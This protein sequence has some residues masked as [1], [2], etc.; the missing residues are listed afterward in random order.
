MFVDK[1]KVMVQAGDGGSGVI[2]FRQE[3]FVDHGGP[4]GGD[5]GKGG[6]V[7]FV[8]SNNQNTLAA[9]RHQKELKAEPGGNGSKQKKH[10]KNG[11]DLIINVPVGT[12]AINESG[13]IIADLTSVGQQVIIA[14]G[15][16]GGFG[17]AHFISSRRQAPR[18]AENGE[19]G[20]KLDL[21]LELKMIANVGL[22]GLPNAGKSTL[23][24]STS[25]AKPEIA[26][27]P[28]T[29]LRPNLGVVDIDKT[30][31]L[32]FA[33]IPGLIEGA[34]KGKGLGDEFLRHVERTS[35]LLHLIDIY[36][37]VAQAYQTIQKEL[38]NYKIDLSTRP[39][40]VVLNKIDGFK[41]ADVKAKLG[42][43]KTVLPPKTPL[44]AISAASKTGVKDLLYEV[45]K[46]V[47]KTIK[48]TKAK[49]SK[50]LPVLRMPSNDDAWQVEKT[51]D[52]F[53]VTGKKIERF[54]ER[55][56]MGN[57]QGVMRLRDIMRKMGIMHELVRKGIQPGHKIIIGQKS[58]Y[59]I[60]F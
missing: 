11:A 33:D 10:G 59:H 25:N 6:N 55:T 4:D 54:A 22:I 43:L 16:L 26:N 46:I 8:S 52:R 35:V 40:I 57:P 28:F 53:V 45:K 2:S 42:E 14:E 48:T 27:Y 18:I 51:D 29:T 5:G 21:T 44:M 34:S 39:Q 60:E 15:G 50:E 31:S 17:N 3:K 19:K 58:E 56:D 32:L 12:I 9:F 24:K 23:L 7:I 13:A 47:A 37:N 1:V 36:E 41:E 49:P 30:T 38:K 20:D